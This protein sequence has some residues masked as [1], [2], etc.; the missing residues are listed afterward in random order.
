MTLEMPS[1]K[2]L[3]LQNL[4]QQYRSELLGKGP[5]ECPQKRVWTFEISPSNNVS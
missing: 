1:E 4:T 2:K 5:Y 3:D